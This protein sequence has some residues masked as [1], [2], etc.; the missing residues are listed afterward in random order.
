MNKYIK[1]LLML[2]LTGVFLTACGS[3]SVKKTTNT[4]S[5]I[6]ISIDTNSSPGPYRTNSL[7]VIKNDLS[8]HLIIRDR[9]NKII[10]EKKGKISQKQFDDLAKLLEKVNLTEIK[11]AKRSEPILGGNNSLMTIKTSKGEYSYRNGSDSTYPNIINQLDAKI[12]K[13][14]LF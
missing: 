12:N 11:S 10:K 7:T 14:H 1:Y 3:A 5:L 2:L 6:S 9:T 4:N 8:T 13:G